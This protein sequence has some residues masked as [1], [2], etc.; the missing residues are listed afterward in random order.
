MLF[1]KS[2][3]AHNARHCI[4][5]AGAEQTTQRA[6]SWQKNHMLATIQIPVLAS[7]SRLGVGL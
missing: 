5:D 7:E 1:R 4:M 3:A 6:E 2:D